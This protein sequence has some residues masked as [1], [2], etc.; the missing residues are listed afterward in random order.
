MTSVTEMEMN[1]ETLNVNYNKSRNKF[2]FCP[3]LYPFSFFIQMMIKSKSL[4][5][6]LLMLLVHQGAILLSHA[7]LILHIQKIDQR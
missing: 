2:H 6:A 5:R 1:I 4:S 7:P 3:R